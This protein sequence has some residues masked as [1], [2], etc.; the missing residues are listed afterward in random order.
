MLM[1]QRTSFKAPKAGLI[2]GLAVAVLGGCSGR[3]ICDRPPDRHP[4]YG[5][6]QHIFADPVGYRYGEFGAY[7]SPIANEPLRRDPR[8]NYPINGSVARP[9]TGPASA[10]AT[11]NGVPA[12]PAAPPSPTTLPAAPP[13]Q[14]N[15]APPAPSAPVIP[16][17]AL[18]P[19][20]QRGPVVQAPGDRAPR[21]TDAPSPAQPA[22]EPAPQ[23]TEGVEAR[24]SIQARRGTFN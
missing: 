15:V 21:I 8:P 18:R 6:P 14:S 2:I 20:G 12:N 23:T 5:E 10:S 22:A 3:N 16:H 1:P 17:A 4:V 13:G 24:P 7:R 19:A 11:G 9:A